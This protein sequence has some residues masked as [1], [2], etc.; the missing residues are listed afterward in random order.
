MM[1]SVT[2]VLTVVTVSKAFPNFH[3][4]NVGDSGGDEIGGVMEY[5]RGE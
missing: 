4:N 5:L 1:R 3:I 2:L